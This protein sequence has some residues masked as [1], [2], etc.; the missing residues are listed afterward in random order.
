MRASEQLC[1]L[2]HSPVPLAAP[3]C[4]LVALVW[5]VGDAGEG[6]G[7]GG[8][9]WTRDEGGHTCVTRKKS[10]QNEKLA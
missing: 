6:V 1:S 5:W 9:G 3:W 7:G 8:G 4:C 2:A 10:K